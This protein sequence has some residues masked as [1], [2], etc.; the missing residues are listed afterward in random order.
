MRLTKFLNKNAMLY[1]KQF[2]FRNNHST[3]HALLEITEKIK[4]TCDTGQI[5]CGVFL[6]LQK[7]LIRLIILFF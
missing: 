7:H 3:T 6:D 5:A 1:K 4:Q 2:R